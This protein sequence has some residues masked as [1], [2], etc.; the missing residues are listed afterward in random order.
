LI[1]AIV[2]GGLGLAGV[3]VSGESA[4]AL[5]LAALAVGTALTFFGVALVQAAT[6]CALVRLDEG[7][8]IGPIGAYRAALARA[9]ALF[10]ATAIA[11]TVCAALSVTLVLAPVA[12]WLAVRWSL[13]AQVVELEGAPAREALRRSG[14]LV[15][16]RWLRVA[17]IVGLGTVIPLAVGTLLGT[18]LIVRADDQL[19]L[20][21][22]ARP[23]R[24]RGGGRA[25]GAAPRDLAL[26]PLMPQL[27]CG[28]IL[29]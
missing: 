4:G 28:T 5:A 16:R 12:I 8:S 19:P 18:L 29:M 1:Q 24:A 10:G 27:G 2:F 13:L 21:R 17:S 3:D 23:P 14:A 22:R 15:R 7:G 20:L 6:A 11:V 26:R 25:R 9:R